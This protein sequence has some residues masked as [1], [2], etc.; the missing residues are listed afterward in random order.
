MKEL[1][2]TNIFWKQLLQFIIAYLLVLF[3]RRY[4][5]TQLIE[6]GIN[7]F[8][9][10]AILSIISN[11][12]VIVLSLLF[13]EKNR[14]HELGGLKGNFFH[15]ITLI[16]FPLIYLVSLNMLFSDEIDKNQLYPNMALLLLYVITI[17]FAEELSMRG[18]IQSFCIK[19]FGDSKKSIFWSILFTSLFF[20]LLHLLKFNNGIY[21]EI[22]QVLYASFIGFMFGT[23]LVVTKRIYPLAIVHALVDFASKLDSAGLPVTEEVSKETPL[24]TS[25]ITVLLVLPCL[26]YGIFIFKKYIKTTK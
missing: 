22:S 17:G 16:I 6:N 12:T 15:K 21:G 5:S 7:S 11:L 24:I 26:L 9:S 8:Q 4:I 3:T 14:L 10:Q 19:C 18:F 13:I 23:I 1:T 2:P 25:I 20:G